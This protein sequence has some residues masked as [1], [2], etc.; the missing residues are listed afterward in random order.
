MSKNNCLRLS[1]G[2]TYP[3]QITRSVRAKR[4]IVKLSN[5]GTLTL[6]LPE[7]ARLDHAQEFIQSKVDWIER[8]LKDVP[9]LDE[10][11]ALLDLKL[12]K[13]KWK[14]VLLA[15]TRCDTFLMEK[16]NNIL[17][18]KGDIENRELLKKLINKWCQ[19]K[20]KP[21]F[22]GMLN[23]LAEQYEF[24]YGRLTV[25]SQKTRWGSCSQ[26]RNI[27]LNSKLLFFDENIV[28]YVMIHELCHTREMNHSRRFWN[29]V[30]GCDPDYLLHQKRLKHLAKKLVL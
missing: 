10:L 22:S 8:K 27:S 4:I 25:R 19:G 28:R 5:S 17:E 18:I 26:K 6:V 21:V 23:D 9:V 3:Y 15:E 1:T 20:A 12:L 30:E 2:Q 24:S 7:K 11:P 14:L 29:L 13:Q 16:P